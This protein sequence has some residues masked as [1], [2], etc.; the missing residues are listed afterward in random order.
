ME[1]ALLTDRKFAGQVLLGKQ[2]LLGK[3]G[4]VG[5]ALNDDNCPANAAVWAR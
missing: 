2:A 5:K 1:Y 3:Q 4:L